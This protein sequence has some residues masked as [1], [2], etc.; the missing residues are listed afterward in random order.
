MIWGV[1]VGAY[2]AKVLCVARVL[3]VAIYC[4]DDT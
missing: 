3:L 1:R 4:E 2:V